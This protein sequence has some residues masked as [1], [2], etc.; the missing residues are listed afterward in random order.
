MNQFRIATAALLLLACLNVPSTAAAAPPAR[1]VRVGGRGVNVGANVGGNHGAHGEFNRGLRLNTGI[2]G[3]ANWGGLGFGL[4]GDFDGSNWE[5]RLPYYALYPPVYYS[6]I[7]PRTY[8]YSPFAYPGYVP[9]PDLASEVGPLEIVNPYV[10]PSNKLESVMP[11]DKRPGGEIPAPA[12][13]IKTRIKAGTIG[14][15]T[16][17]ADSASDSKVLVIINPYVK[18]PSVDGITASETER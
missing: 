13:K 3:A 1:G 11:L 18:Q 16:A 10:T 8:G 15:T 6:G 14:N 17:A 7:V 4:G 2:Y 5:N 9:T 12:E